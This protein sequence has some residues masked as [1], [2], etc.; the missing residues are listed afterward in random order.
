MIIRKIKMFILAGLIT[1]TITGT[2]VNA[3]GKDTYI[4]KEVQEACIKYGE[5]YN[6]CPELLMAICEKESSGRADAVNGTCKGLMQINEIYHR[7]RMERLGVTDIYDIES[8][9]KLA[10]DYLSELF[11]QNEDT[12]LVLM[13]Y[14][15][16]Y[17][18]AKQLYEQDIYSKYAVSVTERTDELERIHG[19]KEVEICGNSNEK[20]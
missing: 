3:A 1:C 12:Y 15:M 8:N 18:R 13:T 11:K 5:E 2:T 17:K 4:P 20:R 19:K 9:V 10:A 16:G 6:I 14:N 7:D